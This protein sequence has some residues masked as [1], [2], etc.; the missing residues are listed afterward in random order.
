MG[1]LVK[2][3][4]YSLKR[5]LS[6]FAVGT[7]ARKNPN[8]RSNPYNLSVILGSC[9]ELSINSENAS[10]SPY[11]MKIREILM[12]AVFNNS[13]TRLGKEKKIN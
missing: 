3:D 1:L 12:L 7:K 5:C 10:A 9:T 6:Y 2:I 4:K 8:L 11:M 13:H